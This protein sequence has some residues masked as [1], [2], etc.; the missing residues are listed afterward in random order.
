MTTGDFANLVE[1]MREAQKKYFRTRNKDSLDASKALE[2]KVDKI[3]LTGSVKEMGDR[4][5]RQIRK[6]INNN[7]RGSFDEV[8][9]YI[10][11]KA[12]SATFFQRVRLAFK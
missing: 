8:R 10:R 11:A 6:A 5:R 7:Y 1:E 12:E 9:M 3:F 2:A 4:Y